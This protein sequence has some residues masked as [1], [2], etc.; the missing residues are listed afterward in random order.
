MN[1]NMKVFLDALA[2]FENVFAVTFPISGLISNGQPPTVEPIPNH[3]FSLL[4]HDGQT[5]P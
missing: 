2:V 1:Q 4:D 3:P 5:D